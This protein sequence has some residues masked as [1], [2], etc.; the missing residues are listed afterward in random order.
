MSGHL[1]AVIL[2]H[3][4]ARRDFLAHDDIFLQAPQV[5]FFRSD[6]GGREHVGRLL[7][8]GG[9]NPRF[10]VERCLRDAEEHRNGGRGGRVAVLDEF[11]AG[12]TPGLCYGHFFENLAFA[13]PLGFN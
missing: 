11:W 5:V 12:K 3:P 9:G 8:G 13:K 10:R 2:P 6:G 1:N 4:R 7:E